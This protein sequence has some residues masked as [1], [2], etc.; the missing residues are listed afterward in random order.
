MKNRIIGALLAALLFA[1][2]AA[3]A[4]LLEYKVTF[5]A[6]AGD[7]D[8]GVGGFYWNDSTHL[9]SNL[10]WDFGGGNSG[11]IDDTKINWSF[12]VFGGT[13]AEFFFEILTGQDVSPAACSTLL[14][15]CGQSFDAPEV[16][17]Y[18][19]TSISFNDVVTTGALQYSINGAFPVPSVFGS[20]STEFVGQVAQVPL[21]GTLALIAIAACGYG[22]ST[23]RTR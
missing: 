18:P 11:G 9:I 7:A 14:T 16:F 23:R 15:G 10:S 20:F 1:P 8:G 21:P 12:E 22:F 5:G 4:A 3:S 6:N 13:L 17:G 19:P 2:F